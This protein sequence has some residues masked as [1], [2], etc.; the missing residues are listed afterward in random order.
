MST[1]QPL[2]VTG[3]EERLRG[4]ALVAVPPAGGEAAFI[5]LLASVLVRVCAQPVAHMLSHPAT[6]T[7]Q[8]AA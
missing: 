6:R 5:A 4:V 2:V 1:D 8:A 3:H 7:T